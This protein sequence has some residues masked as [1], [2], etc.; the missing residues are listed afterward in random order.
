[1]LAPH[2]PRRAALPF[3]RPLHWGPA[4]PAQGGNR[5]GG[6]GRR[7]HA[8]TRPFARVPLSVL[9]GATA[10]TRIG[11]GSAERVTVVD[12]NATTFTFRWPPPP[13]SSRHPPQITATKHHSI[14]ALPSSD[15]SKSLCSALL[16]SVDGRGGALLLQGAQ[17]DGGLVVWRSD[18]GPPLARVIEHASVIT[19]VG[20]SSNGGLLITGAA[21][22]TAV[23]WAR[24]ASM[25][26]GGLAAGAAEGRP[27]ATRALRGHVQAL[28]AVA[29]CSEMGVAASGACDGTVLLHSLNG[30]LLRSLR[31]PGASAVAHVHLSALHL[32]L[33]LGSAASSTLHVYSLSGGHLYDLTTHSAIRCVLVGEEGT[34]F[35]G[36]VQGELQAWSL[37]TGEVCA[38]FD[39]VSA[40]ISALYASSESE[41]LCGTQEGELLAYALDPEAM[42]GRGTRDCSNW[43]LAEGLLEG[44]A[45]PSASRPLVR[46]P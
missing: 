1:M 22:A 41:L 5:R 26:S 10:L 12:A 32:R 11:A 37:I 27:V 40:G 38:L 6:G 36:C 2:P 39:K 14:L 8:P 25:I 18:G 31:T 24:S 3:V 15:A 33:V 29:V 42:Y 20:H 34:L 19:C 7:A 35:A 17:I 23:L 30:E 4:P 45:P 16:P 46:E 44:P 9:S 43:A 21:D 28:T 13:A